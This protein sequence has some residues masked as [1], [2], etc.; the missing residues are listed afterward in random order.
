MWSPLHRNCQTFFDTDFQY[1]NKISSKHALWRKW[2]KI[3]SSSTFSQM[4]LNL[5]NFYP[6]REFW[7]YNNIQNILGSGTIVTTKLL[8]YCCVQMIQL[9]ILNHYRKILVI[10]KITIKTHTLRL[11]VLCTTPP[12]RVWHA[13]I[14]EA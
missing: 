11:L 13:E 4:F 10:I 12:P 5:M 1:K 14:R 2:N 3:A 9:L 7:Q 6:P 8:L